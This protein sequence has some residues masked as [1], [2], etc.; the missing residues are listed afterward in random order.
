MAAHFADDFMFL[1]KAVKHLAQLASD[2]FRICLQAFLVD[3][4]QNGAA[5]G[6]G[7][8]ACAIGME[9]EF[10][11]QR[12][13]HMALGDN[14]GQWEA[15]AD[16]FGHD[17]DFGNDAMGFEAPEIV[18]GA[19][20]AGLDL[21]DDHQPATL[22]H[23]GGGGGEI[24]VRGFNNAAIALDGFNNEARKLS[25]SCVL[26]GAVN[27]REVGVRIIAE[28]APV[29]IRIGH[30]MNSGEEGDVV[31]EA[32]DAGERLGPDGGAMIG[33]AQRQH[34]NVAGELLGHDQG[35]I[36]GFGAAVGEMHHPVVALGHA[37]GELFGKM[38]WHRMIKHGGAVLELFDLLPDGCR[39]GGM[40]VANRDADV[41][42][43][44]IE[45]FL[46]GFIPEILAVAFG[47]NERGLVGHKG[48]LGSG[49]VFFPPGY[50]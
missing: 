6:T 35:E 50:N 1:V 46:A 18:A 12:I 48:A 24:T 11:C 30:V 3:D 41:H 5:G 16:A 39:D 37:G 42:P 40:V 31:A 8:W 25:R 4:L 19:A 10:S 32:A 14:G 23:L 17:D 47:E 44:E 15:I 27:F 9:R 13:S 38:G 34:V 2:L 28:Y 7:G 43:Q 20:K 49:V 22:A 21:V 36:D 33:I 26:D 45:I 29:G